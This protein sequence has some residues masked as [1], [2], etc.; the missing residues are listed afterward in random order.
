VAV[1]G[2]GALWALP[3]FADP[4]PCDEG[5]DMDISLARVRAAAWLLLGLPLVAN[6]G[7]SFDETTQLAREQAPALQAQRSS[8]DGAHA[9]K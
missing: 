8:L 9:R 4:C 3:L 2:V 1:S 6:A 7:L 5:N